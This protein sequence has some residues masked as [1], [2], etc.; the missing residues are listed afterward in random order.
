MCFVARRWW[1][2]HLEWSL[3]PMAHYELYRTNWNCTSRFWFTLIPWW[4]VKIPQKLTPYS[5]K[6]FQI[7]E[8]IHGMFDLVVGEP[9]LL[10]W[11]VVLLKKKKKKKRERKIIPNCTSWS[12][13]HCYI[14]YRSHSIM[15]IF[16][17]IFQVSNKMSSGEWVYLCVQD[18]QTGHV[19][20]LQ[21]NRAMLAA[22]SQ[23][24]SKAEKDAFAAMLGKRSWLTDATRTTAGERRGWW[25]NLVSTTVL[26][27]AREI[28][29]VECSPV[30]WIHVN[31][32]CSSGY[33][34]RFSWPNGPRRP[35]GTRAVCCFPDFYNLSLIQSCF[36]WREKQSAKILWQEFGEFREI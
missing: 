20:T 35:C 18:L 33:P 25:N 17:R 26:C 9:K 5:P 28:S 15:W 8:C 12:W 27:H 13:L 2:M 4:N 10:R 31:D 6:Y 1:V 34:K 11:H 24:E 30:A 19:I 22:Q 32:Y 23:A 14:G 3:R 29:V 21:D 36:K 7:Y 16:L